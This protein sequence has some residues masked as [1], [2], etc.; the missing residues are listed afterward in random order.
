M[1]ETMKVTNIKT[2][3]LIPAN[4]NPRQ[5]S[6]IG[7]QQIKESLESFGFVNPIVVN[8]YKGRENIVIG[9]HQRIKVWEA[10][11]NEHV[12]AIEVS[13]P[14]EKEKELNIRL[15]KAGGAWDWDVLANEFELTDLLDW[16]F[17]ESDF[18]FGS[19]FDGA[20]DGAVDLDLELPGGLEEA[21][22]RMVQIFLNDRTHKTFMDTVKEAKEEGETITD[23]VYRLVTA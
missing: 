1:R 18:S 11:G 22:V 19:E 7:Y 12:P 17:S 3:D 4:Y 20:E 21:G 10:M 8:T 15:N 23:T 14:L 2:K 6:K 9:G 16:G 13:L 5:L